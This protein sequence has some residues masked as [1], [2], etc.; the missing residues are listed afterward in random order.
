MK[1]I[2]KEKSINVYNQDV[3]KLGRYEYTGDDRYS[4]VTAGKKQSEEIL[5]SIKS[6]RLKKPFRILDVGSGDGTY[7]FE[8]YEKLRP[9]FIVGFDFAKGGVG[10][11]RKRVRKKD[12]RKIRFI[13]SSIYSV[14]KKIKEKFDVA[15]IRGVL[16]HLYYPEKGIKAVCKLSDL[17]VVAE[18]NGYSP[19]MKM[20]EKIS[21]YHRKHEEKSYWPPVLNSWFEKNGFRVKKQYFFGPV[22]FFFPEIP[23]RIIKKIEPFVENIPYINRIYCASNLIIYERKPQ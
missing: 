22:P 13:N 11:A 21:P 7:T 15:V 19:L 18:P 20:M 8:L 9:K 16:H 10:I 2:T 23:A 1:K 4:A 6:Q 14:D 5:K 12:V 3:K 17:I